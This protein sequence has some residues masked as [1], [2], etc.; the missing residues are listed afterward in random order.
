MDGNETNETPKRKK[1]RPDW[2]SAFLTLIRG[3][4]A[5]IHACI[6]LKISKVTVYRR[7]DSDPVFKQKYEEAVE[8]QTTALL[9]EAFRRAHDGVEQ[10]V[11]YKGEQVSFVREYSDSLLMFLIRGRDPQ[12][13]DST[14]MQVAGDPSNP[15][16][17]QHQHSGAIL[18]LP[19][20]EIDDT[21]EDP[22][23]AGAA[24]PVLNV[25]G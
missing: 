14:R 4:S 10:P 24:T 9:A 22:T 20:K 3:G 16:Q 8:Y 7:L 15:I 13:R 21:D 25:P 12:Y 6:K 2:A 17:H 19:E 1:R 18:I 5:I 23:A 11:F